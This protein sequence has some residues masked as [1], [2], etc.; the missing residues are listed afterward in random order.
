[1][2]VLVLLANTALQVTLWRPPDPGGTQL[3]QRLLGEFNG[4]LE[5]QLVLVPPESGAGPLGV[6]FSRAKVTANCLEALDSAVEGRLHESLIFLDSTGARR[7]RNWLQE[8]CVPFQ[9]SPVVEVIESPRYEAGIL[10]RRLRGEPR[11]V[12][13]IEAVDRALLVPL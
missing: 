11:D 6:A 5:G 3:T 8:R 10:S 2:W 9:I 4:S 12:L 1:M 13:G 7:N